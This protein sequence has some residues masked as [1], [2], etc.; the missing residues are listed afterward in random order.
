VNRPRTRRSRRCHYPGLR[1]INLWQHFVVTGW[2]EGSDSR[3]SRLLRSS[4]YSRLTGG[5]RPGSTLPGPLD[6]VTIGRGRPDG[7]AGS[8]LKADRRKEGLRRRAPAA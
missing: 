4:T 1:G 8:G 7:D 2:R 3:P 6:A 5:P